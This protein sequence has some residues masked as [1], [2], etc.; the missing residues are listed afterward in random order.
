M[1]TR[2]QFGMAELV[3]R[4][5]VPAPSIHHYLRMGL[6][7]RPRLVAPN[8]FAYDQRHEQA[9]L[10]IRL[11]RERRR[12]SLNVIRRVLPELLRLDEEQAFRP[13]MWD[14]VV[15]AQ[16]ARAG[17]RTPKGKLLGA[18]MEAFAKRGYGDVN[19]DDIARA[20]GIAKGSL[21]RHFRNK[22]DLF[23]AAAEAAANEVVKEFAGAWTDGGAPGR[24]D[25][26]DV[27]ARALEPS[28]PIFMDLF[29]RA[30]QRR[31]GYPRTARRIFSDMAG[32][33]GEQLGAEDRIAAGAG[34]LRRS[35]ASLFTTVL[36]P[37]ASVVDAVRGDATTA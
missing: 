8:R 11:L 2:E 13:D 36:Q 7:P 15:G 37:S 31:P 23:F 35:A 14:Q 16:L 32:A 24:A 19:V 22:E 25:P 12:L 34:L 1:I 26:A 3:E 18:A 27:L 20:A 6:L 10:L 33:L 28:L 30:L 17:R 5:G 9:L 4:T 21:Y 29:T